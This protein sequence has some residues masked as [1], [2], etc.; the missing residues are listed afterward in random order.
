MMIGSLKR[1]AVTLGPRHAVIAAHPLLGVA[2]LLVAD[3]HDGSAIQPGETPDDG[4]VVRVHPVAVQFVPLLAEH[5]NVIECVR[6]LRM[7]R[8]LHHLPRGE[9]G[10]DAGRQC[11]TLRLQARDLLTDVDLGVGGNK[12]QLV[13]FRLEL[14]DRLLEFQEGQRHGRSGC[15]RARHGANTAARTA[16]RPPGALSPARL[17]RCGTCAANR[18]PRPTRAGTRNSAPCG[19]PAPD[20]ASGSS[21][22][23][24]P[25]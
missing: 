13:D 18:H 22:G 19:T 6:P 7:P 24:R 21:P 9:V 23:R 10:E 4:L 12:T 16:A 2:A 14:G 8:E 25:M 15:R 11:T 20:A 3:Q 17:A 5:R 1:S